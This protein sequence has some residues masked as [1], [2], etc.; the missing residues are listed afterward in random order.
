MSL[1]AAVGIKPPPGIKK[2]EVR[3]Y[4]DIGNGGADEILR[5]TLMTVGDQGRCYRIVTDSFGRKDNSDWTRGTATAAARAGGAGSS[6]YKQDAEVEESS[7][8]V[9]FHSH[10]HRHGN[11]GGRGRKRRME[12]AHQPYIEG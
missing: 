9:I 7:H 11:G 1:S 2:K 3:Y 12:P 5:P 4:P 8:N 10:D 6:E